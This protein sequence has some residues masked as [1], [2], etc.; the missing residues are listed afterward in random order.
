MAL[1]IRSFVGLSGDH[2]APSALC[3]VTV[4]VTLLLAI[5]GATFFCQYL[6]PEE[7]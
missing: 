2:D 5:V 1:L 4:L 6:P 3:H 7:L